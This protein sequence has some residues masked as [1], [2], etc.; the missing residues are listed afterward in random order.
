MLF[1][2][3]Q[4]GMSVWNVENCLVGWL[5]FF[6]ESLNVRVFFLCDFSDIFF[7][8]YRQRYAQRCFYWQFNHQLIFHV[9]KDRI[10]NETADLVPRD[11]LNNEKITAKAKM[12]KI[13]DYLPEA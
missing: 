12:A 10:K 11:K 8:N 13:Q 7:S 5:V 1:F 2:L 4:N 6:A 3:Y 9:E